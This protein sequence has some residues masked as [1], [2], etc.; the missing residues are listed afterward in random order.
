MGRHQLSV[1]ITPRVHGDALGRVTTPI[2]VPF[3]FEV[4]SRPWYGLQ[5]CPRRVFQRLH[6]PPVYRYVSML[7]HA[8]RPLSNQTKAQILAHN[9]GNLDI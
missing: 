1:G 8:K 5:L 9:S 3:V 4:A 7:R 6:Q 2:P